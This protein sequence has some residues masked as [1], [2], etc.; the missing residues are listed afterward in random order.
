MPR[1]DRSVVQATGWGWSLPA[2]VL[3]QEF[4]RGGNLQRKTLRYF[5]LSCLTPRPRPRACATACTPSRRGWR[6]GS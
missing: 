6:A 3:K 2:E 4:R 1:I 5:D